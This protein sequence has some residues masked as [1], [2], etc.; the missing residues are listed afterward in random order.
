MSS[1]SSSPSGGSRPARGSTSTA[2]ARGSGGISAAVSPVAGRG[3]GGGDASAAATPRDYGDD[4]DTPQ[5]VGTMPRTGHRHAPAQRR[6]SAQHATGQIRD[7]TAAALRNW[8]ARVRKDEM[9]FLERLIRRTFD[10]SK[11]D[12]V[13]G[14]PAWLERLLNSDRGRERVLFSLA[15]RHPNCLLITI[16][17]QHAWNHGH[18]D[19]V[20][21]LGPAAA[22]Y[23]SIFHELLADHLRD[24][25]AAGTTRTKRW[26]PSTSSNARARNPSRRTSSRR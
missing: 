21:A 9:W 8:R 22:S 14:R 19:E 4:D 15:E 7:K 25:I 23:F 13:R 11:V 18:A 3:S 12:A 24:L 20:R 10:P 16:A 26:T 5:G 1:G 6:R 17:I 2:A